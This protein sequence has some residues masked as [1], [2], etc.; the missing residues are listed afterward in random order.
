[1]RLFHQIKAKHKNQNSNSQE[2]L[3]SNHDKLLLQNG[4]QSRPK[5]EAKNLESLSTDPGAADWSL[6][7]IKK[8]KRKMKTMILSLKLHTLL[9]F[10]KQDSKELSPKSLDKMLLKLCTI[11]FSKSSNSLYLNCYDSYDSQTCLNML[12]QD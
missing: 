3:D 12:K 10:F 4:I 9:F 5:N 8:S 1:M 7:T 6:V 2:I 11:Q